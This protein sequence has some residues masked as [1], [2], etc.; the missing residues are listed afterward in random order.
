MNMFDRSDM[1][2][3]SLFPRHSH[4]SGACARNAFVA[5]GFEDRFALYL[6][7]GV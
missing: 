1:L 2:G 7:Y 4:R 3:E 6:Y 5:I